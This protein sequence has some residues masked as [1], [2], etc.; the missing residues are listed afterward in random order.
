MMASDNKPSRTAASGQ[1]PRSATS[2]GLIPV[3]GLVEYLASY[4]LPATEPEPRKPKAPRKPR[5]P[6]PNERRAA[7][8]LRMPGH[9]SSCHQAALAV[10]QL[11]A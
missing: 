10:R 1:V 3:S 11:R 4:Y 2:G 5:R 6:V 7:P 9:R 8:R